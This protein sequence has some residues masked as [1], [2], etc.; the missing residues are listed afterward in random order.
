M[1]WTLRETETTDE[2]PVWYRSIYTCFHGF[3]GQVIYSIVPKPRR[4]TP[5]FWIIQICNAQVSNQKRAQRGIRGYMCIFCAMQCNPNPA[6]SKSSHGAGVTVLSSETVNEASS[7]SSRRA[8]SSTAEQKQSRLAG[9]P[10]PYLHKYICI[11]VVNSHFPNISLETL[12]NL[13]CNWSRSSSTAA[14]NWPCAS[15]L[16]R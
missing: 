3:P 9:H 8:I 10:N 13:C 7:S 11:S 12:S 1:H 15:E 6:R 4:R 2:V 16:C 5:N 14:L